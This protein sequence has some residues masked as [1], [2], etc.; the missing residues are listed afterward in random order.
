VG[1]AKSRASTGAVLAYWLGNPML[2]PATLIFLGFVLGWQWAA[3]RAATGILL[4]LGVAYL[5]ERFVAGRG[6]RPA[7]SAP[8]VPDAVPDRRP[9]L[10]RWA[11]A[12]G[13]LAVG[14]VPEYFL[15]VVVLGAVRAWLFPAMSPA[16]GHSLW[17]IVGLALA[18]TLFVVPTAGE[19]PIV[20]TL[21]AFG[22]GAGGAGALLVTLP[23][24]SLPSLVMVG[25]AV[26]VRTLA[27]VAGSVAVLG[28]LT[29]LAALV[30]R[31]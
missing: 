2:N 30:L 26:P 4:V 6:A 5:A 28:V 13:Q 15:I 22:L 19:V 24:V 8:G 23:P 29:G 10:V 1:L 20:Q 31:L 21:L 17:L 18:G 16:I 9:L 14:L 25:R 3:L 27:F 11:S 12:F 7:A